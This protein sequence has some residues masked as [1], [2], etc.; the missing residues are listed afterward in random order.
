M[1]KKYFSGVYY[2]L[3]FVLTLVALAVSAIVTRLASKS[4]GPTPP[5]KIL[6]LVKFSNSSPISKSNSDNKT[7]ACSS[8]NHNMKVTRLD[9]E[10]RNF[11]SDVWKN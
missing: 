3:M 4:T 11:V 1:N 8:N 6:K 7:F 10:S 2:N 5:P 9:S